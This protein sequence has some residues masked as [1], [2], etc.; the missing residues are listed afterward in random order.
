MPYRGTNAKRNVVHDKSRA[1]IKS[2][3]REHFLN[4]KKEH[5]H[6]LANAKEKI[7]K[8]Y[9]DGYR[10]KEK[11][12]LLKSVRVKFVNA[13]QQEQYLD[14]EFP[15]NVNHLKDLLSNPSAQ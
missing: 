2:V 4:E 13:D 6:E 7:L 1:T 10:F 3:S 11:E 5:E 8:L 12:D 15:D 14:F 9:N